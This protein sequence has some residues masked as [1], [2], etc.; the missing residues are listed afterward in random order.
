MN[1][2]ENVNCKGGNVDRRM[3]AGEMETVQGWRMICY[4]SFP[5]VGAEI[6]NIR[7]I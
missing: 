6:T 5:E 7:H 4:L 3:V 2:E 1:A